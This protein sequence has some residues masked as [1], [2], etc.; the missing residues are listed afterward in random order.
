MWDVLIAQTARP[1]LKVTPFV[2]VGTAAVML[3]ALR[4]ISECLLPVVMA[5]RRWSPQTSVLPAPNQCH[6]VDSRLFE[7]HNQPALPRASVVLAIE[8]SQQEGVCR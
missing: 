7:D 2:A 6:G 1:Y 5:R 3:S 4:F 8:A